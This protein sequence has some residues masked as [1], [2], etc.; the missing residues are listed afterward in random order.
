M[1]VAARAAVAEQFSGVALQPSRG[2]GF[3]ERDVH[4]GA[5]VHIVA[6]GIVQAREDDLDCLKPPEQQVHGFVERRRSLRAL[7]GRSLLGRIPREF[8]GPSGVDTGSSIRIACGEL[9]ITDEDDVAVLRDQRTVDQY[10]S[11]VAFDQV[12]AAR[13]SLELHV[14]SVLLIAIESRRLALALDTN[15]PKQRRVHRAR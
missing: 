9:V 3:L 6:A 13:P 5:P 7:A 8:G 15:A 4:D 14:Q 2:E 11:R 1:P 10:V 12:P